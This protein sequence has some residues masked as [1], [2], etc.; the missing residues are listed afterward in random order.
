MAPQIIQMLSAALKGNESL[1]IIVITITLVFS[2]I[3]LVKKLLAVI[4]KSK[5]DLIFLNKDQVIWNQFIK[6]IFFISLIDL[7][8]LLWGYFAGSTLHDVSSFNEFSHWLAVLSLLAILATSIVILIIKHYPV[9]RKGRFYRGTFIING[10][11]SYIVILYLILHSYYFY[12]RNTVTLFQLVQI[13]TLL[14]ILCTLLLITYGKYI[15]I[16]LGQIPKENTEKFVRFMFLGAKDE[17]EVP[18]Y[19]LHTIDSKHLVLSDNPYEYKA[20]NYYLYNRETNKYEHFV[21]KNIKE[22]EKQTRLERFKRN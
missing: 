12:F 21:K 15:L 9:S 17:V 22:N 1:F 18:L 8:I 16:Q 6:I 4:T 2:A 11:S 13:L 5:F 3:I 7:F 20:E 14:V 19:I 10:I